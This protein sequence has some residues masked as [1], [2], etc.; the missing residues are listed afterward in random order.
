MTIEIQP[1]ERVIL[2]TQR[3]SIRKVTSSVPEGISAFKRELQEAIY[4]SWNNKCFIK[5]SGSTSWCLKRYP[6]DECQVEF[7]VKWVEF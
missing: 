1:L 5:A 6:I 7:R 4:R 2:V 3:W